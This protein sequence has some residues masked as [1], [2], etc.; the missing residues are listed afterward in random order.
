MKRIILHW[1]GG[2]Y[3]PNTHE[4]ESYHYLINGDG[5]V[6][7]GKYTP[8]D[9]LNCKDGV[10]SAHTGG[11]NTVS[12]GIALCGMFGYEFNGKVRKL[13]SYP[14]R[15]IQ[16]ERM[17]E[18]CAELLKKYNLPLSPD[19]V[20]THYE[21]GLKNPHSSSKGKPDINFI[22]YQPNIQADNV[23]EFIRGK[24]VWYFAK[25]K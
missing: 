4:F 6:I 8:E 19:T 11:G 12:I 7:E 18:L 24:V 22:P 14:L 23:G 25:L 3:Q 16:F 21:F 10:Y 9:N 1:T 5:L 2:T 15:Q 17:F 13:G 20:M